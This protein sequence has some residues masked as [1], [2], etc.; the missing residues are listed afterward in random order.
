MERAAT[1]YRDGK[2][3]GFVAKEVTQ[4]LAFVLEVERVRSKRDK[5]L[6]QMRARP[7]TDEQ[8]ISGGWLGVPAT[9][10]HI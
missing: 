6:H 3:I 1:Y 9:G 10:N 5:L 2:A 4:D 7:R 8:P